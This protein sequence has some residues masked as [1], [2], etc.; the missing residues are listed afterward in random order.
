MWSASLATETEIKDLRGDLYNQ[1]IITV[2]IEFYKIF[3]K[4]IQII[5][6]DLQ[7]RVG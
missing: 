6:G 2:K 1:N 4:E 5:I 3:F 7:E